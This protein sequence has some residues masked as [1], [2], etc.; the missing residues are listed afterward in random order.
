MPEGRKI[1]CEHAVRTSRDEEELANPER[2]R[3]DAENAHRR[4]RRNAQQDAYKTT[5]GA[6]GTYA[7]F[8][9]MSAGYRHGHPSADGYAQYIG[10]LGLVPATARSL[11]SQSV[12]R[13]LPAK[14]GCGTSDCGYRPHSRKTRQSECSDECGPE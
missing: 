1:A 14:R 4:C 5:E 6:R 11:H 7:P 13:T 10:F 8:M 3:D 12:L 2:C 9:L